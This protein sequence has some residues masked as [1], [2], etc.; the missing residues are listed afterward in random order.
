M[1]VLS[2]FGEASRTQVTTANNNQ[3]LAAVNTTTTFTGFTFITDI[4]SC[5][6]SSNAGD[7]LN[8]GSYSVVE[9]D[10]TT[11]GGLTLNDNQPQ[12]AGESVNCTVSHKTST[13]ASNNVSTLTTKLATSIVW[14]GVLIVVAFASLVLVMVRKGA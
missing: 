2:G 10:D 6:N 9:G 1:M 14:L 3:L 8:A 4:S 13:T 12:F 5:V 11:D 7:S